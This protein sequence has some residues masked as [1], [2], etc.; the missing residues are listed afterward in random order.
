MKLWVDD[1]LA[2][3]MEMGLTDEEFGVYWKLLLVAWQRPRIFADVKQNARWTSC[4]PAKLKKLWPA[5]AHKWH[6]DG[7]GGLVNL[8]M[9]AVR[10]DALS[11]SSK[12]TAAANARWERERLRQAAEEGSQAA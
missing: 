6:P 1:A 7:S 2:D 8:K 3:A 11:K 5:F 4:S 12:A 10:A 9:E